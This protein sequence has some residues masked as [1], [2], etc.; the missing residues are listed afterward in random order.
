[1]TSMPNSS[2]RT[3]SRKRCYWTCIKSRWGYKLPVCVFQSHIMYLTHSLTRSSNTSHG[4][5][6]RL[7]LHS[8]V[9]RFLRCNHSETVQL[10]TMARWLSPLIASTTCCDLLNVQPLNDGVLS[11]KTNAGARRSKRVVDVARR[12]VQGIVT[13]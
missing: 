5:G 6:F 12:R 9:P 2:M 13:S 1:M 10:M 4:T 3:I 7:R 8:P 11:L